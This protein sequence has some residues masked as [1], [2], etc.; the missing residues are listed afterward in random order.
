VSG[1]ALTLAGLLPASLAGVLAAVLALLIAWHLRATHRAAMPE[2]RRRIRL[3]NGYLMILSMP[4]L[5][6]CLGVASPASPRGFVLS[7]G[8]MV[9]VVGLVAMLAIADMLNNMRLARRAQAEL[10]REAADLR[11]EVDDMRAARRGGGAA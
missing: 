8:S 4:L 3:A 2:S 5:A 9:A 7:W 6:Y 11:R 10:R 1:A